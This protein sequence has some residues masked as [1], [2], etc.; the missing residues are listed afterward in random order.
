MEKGCTILEIIKIC[1]NLEPLCF[2]LKKYFIQNTV[3]NEC[4]DTNVRNKIKQI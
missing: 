3:Y 4:A 2:N 1:T